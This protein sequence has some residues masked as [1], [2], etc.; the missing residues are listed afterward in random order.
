MV[1]SPMSHPGDFS[2]LI[3]ICNSF[4]FHFIHL[5]FSLSSGSLV[6]KK[7]KIKKGSSPTIDILCALLG[8]AQKSHFP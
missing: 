7:K 3:G 8:P 1:I 2:H 4:S 6:K 5:L